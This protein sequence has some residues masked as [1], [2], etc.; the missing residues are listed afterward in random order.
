MA[1][2]RSAHL[3]IGGLLAL[4]SALCGRAHA[5]DGVIEINQ[6]IASKGGV[7]P[8]DTVPGFPSPFP[9]AHFPMSP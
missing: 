7:V 5:V 2:N 9:P 4:M 1:Y 6:A 3:L 8:G